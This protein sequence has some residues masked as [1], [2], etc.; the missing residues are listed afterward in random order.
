MPADPLPALPAERPAPRLG[1][2]FWVF[3]LLAWT[4]IGAFFGTRA[5][6]LAVA[7]GRPLPDLRILVSNLYDAYLWAL[8]TPV[9]FLAAARYP[10][11][12][13]TWRRSLL[14]HAAVSSLV[15]VAG[16]AANVP[17]ASYLWPDEP[18]TFGRYLVG[19]FHFNVQW[20][21]VVVMVQ[22]AL[23]Y[24]TR[25]RDRDV[26][27]AQLET[28]LARAQLDAL[29]MQIQ[30]H[31]LFNTLHAVSE[32]VH[33]DP[34]GADRMITR[35]GDLLRLTVDDAAQEVPLRRELHFLQAYLEIERTRFQD[36]LTV[37]MA[38]DPDTLDAMVPNLV[39]QPLVE[40]AIRHGTAPHAA[41][42][43]VH[44]RARRDGA[45]LRLEVRDNGGGLRPRQPGGRE[46]V[47]LRN[48]RARLRQLYG[49]AGTLELA[50]GDAG[51]VRAAVS[52]PFRA[53]PEE[54]RPAPRIPGSPRVL[55]VMEGP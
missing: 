14:A 51:G 18:A 24:A 10:F 33:E 32:L 21:F 7:Q 40:N 42:G 6:A 54:V 48:T 16:V 8:F 46:G 1:W 19:T 17:F 31:F 3:N 22:H 35:L 44:V 12:R 5:Y 36:R 55:H 28:Q 39:L 2:R 26:Q 50:N 9:I 23:A 4:I 38:V 52:L 15:A 30:P 41:H 11:A 20:Y 37:E 53:A 47:G 29:K 49:E 45:T 13:G 27:A 25:L 43:V 34:D